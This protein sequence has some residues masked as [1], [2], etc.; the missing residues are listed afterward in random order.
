MP[1]YRGLVNR[2]ERK[3]MKSPGFRRKPGQ[4]FYISGM[5]ESRACPLRSDS[6]GVDRSGAETLDAEGR[7]PLSSFPC[8]GVRRA[9]DI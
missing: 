8:F 3:I 2:S 4:V 6:E 9:M 1:E 7:Q 5:N